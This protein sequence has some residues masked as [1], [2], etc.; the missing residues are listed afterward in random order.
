MIYLSINKTELKII[1]VNNTPASP[2]TVIQRPSRKITIIVL[3]TKSFIELA[4]YTRTT[5]L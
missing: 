1:N 2:P 4:G 5:L 3:T